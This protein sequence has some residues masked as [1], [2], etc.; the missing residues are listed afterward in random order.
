MEW[1]KNKYVLMLIAAV[2]AVYL[3]RRSA[4]FN[5]LVGKLPGMSTAAPSPIAVPTKK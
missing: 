4:V 2:A 1:L 5:Q 3:M